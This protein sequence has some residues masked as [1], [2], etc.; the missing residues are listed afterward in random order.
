VNENRDKR[1]DR[2]DKGEATQGKGGRSGGREKETRQGEGSNCFIIEIDV[3][4]LRWSWI[5][6][7]AR[8][9]RGSEADLK[10][11]KE[12]EREGRSDIL[13]YR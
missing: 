1:V 4:A 8:R 7:E 2:P 6:V 11:H 13:K 9:K 12:T 10:S 5:G 3:D